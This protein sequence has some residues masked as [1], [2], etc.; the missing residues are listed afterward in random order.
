MNFKL[1]LVAAA[2]AVSAQSALSRN[3]VWN[4]EGVFTSV[5]IEYQAV[6]VNIGDTLSGTIQFNTNA[7]DAHPESPIVGQYDLGKLTVCVPALGT[8]VTFSGPHTSHVMTVINDSPPGDEPPF[9]SL[10]IAGRDVP[11]DSTADP[12]KSFFF[13]GLLPVDT[14]SSDGIPLTPPPKSTF[15]FLNFQYMDAVISTS[16]G[17]TGTITAISSR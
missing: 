7:R 11:L 6:G 15:Q 10:E 12:T 16:V 9:D 3:L 5:P 4:F 1:V 2:F 13:N 14:F 17:A 8:C